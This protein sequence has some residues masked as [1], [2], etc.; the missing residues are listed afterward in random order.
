MKSQMISPF[1]FGR[2]PHVPSRLL[3]TQCRAPRAFTAL[4]ART[5]RQPQDTTVNQPDTSGGVRLKMASFM[6]TLSVRRPAGFSR[7]ISVCLLLIF[8]KMLTSLVLFAGVFIV[9]KEALISPFQFCPTR[10]HGELSCNL[11][12]RPISGGESEMKMNLLATAVILCLYIPVV[13][14]AFA[15]LAM[16]LAAYTKDRAA[17]WFSAACQAASS[18][19]VLT[20]IIVFLAL[21]QTYVNWEHMTIWFYL[22]VLVQ[23]ELLITTVLTCI[24]GKRL[25][26]EWE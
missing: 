26:S 13:F 12:R 23:V 11:P 17:L 25:T 1:R 5:L 21:Y 7:W 20:G 18:L 2:R 15:L 14:V 24:C 19:L 22:C 6:T 8:I 4:Y 10:H 16:L 9:S 3:H